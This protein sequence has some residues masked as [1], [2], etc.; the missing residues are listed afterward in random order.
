MRDASPRL[1]LAIIINALA[2]NLYLSH[3]RH[4]K[5]SPEAGTIIPPRIVI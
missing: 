2:I 4:A 3:L 1:I 5:K